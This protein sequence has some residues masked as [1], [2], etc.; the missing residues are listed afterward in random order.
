MRDGDI[1]VFN[2]QPTLHKMSMMGHRVKVL[3]WSTF[4]MN[5]SVTSPYNANFDGDEMNLHLPQSLETRAEISE[6][7]MAYRQLITPQ[8]NKPVMGI[9]QDTLCAVPLAAQSTIALLYNYVFYVIKNPINSKLYLKIAKAGKKSFEKNSILVAEYLIGE[10]VD[11]NWIFI[12]I[13]DGLKPI[14]LSTVLSKLWITKKVVLT[15]VKISASEIPSF[16]HFLYRL[17]ISI[18]KLKN[19]NM[20]L[21]DFLYLSSNVEKI[22]LSDTTVK[23]DDGSIVS[24]VDLLKTLSKVK[25]LKYQNFLN[26]SKISN[27]SATKLLEIPHFSNISRFYLSVTTEDFDINAFFNYTHFFQQ[28]SI[29]KYRLW[30]FTSSAD[31]KNRLEQ[32]VDE[33][34]EAENQ[35]AMNEPLYVFFF[36]LSAAKVAKMQQ[37]CGIQ[38]KI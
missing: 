9:V 22:N 8:A 25:Y 18:L 10:Y 36:G 14:G 12:G 16:T 24:F 17:D 6:I 3:P 31:L 20:S 26:T 35:P 33:I 30:F 28:S 23:N 21:F 5:L 15:Q 2:R 1:I 27:D 29:N 13:N 37:L 7:A 4:R 19:Q 38:K 32:V 11:G 34:L